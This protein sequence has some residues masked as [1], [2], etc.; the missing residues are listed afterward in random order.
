MP[1]IYGEGGERAFLRLQEHIMSRTRDYSILAWGFQNKMMSVSTVYKDWTPGGVFAASP[2]DFQH[3]DSIVR[4]YRHNEPL[5][6]LEISAGNVRAS[7]SLI[8]S[9]LCPVALLNCAPGGD[10]KRIIGIV[11]K[12]T[13]SRDANEYVRRPGCN[14]VKE[15]NGPTHIEGEQKTINIRTDSRLETL[16]FGQVLCVY[17]TED[18][19]DLGMEVADVWPRSAWDSKQPALVPKTLLTEARVEHPM[20]VRFRH[21]EEG[22]RDFFLAIYFRQ[23]GYTTTIRSY[24]IATCSRHTPLEEISGELP[25]LTERVFGSTKASNRALNLA[26]TVEAI[27]GTLMWVIRPHRMNRTPDVTIDATVELQ[28]MAEAPLEE[29]QRRPLASRLLSKLRRDEGVAAGN[30]S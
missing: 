27:P 9:A 26:L 17:N 4:L 5:E 18:F 6:T 14:P 1:L 29:S 10:P 12:S 21:E 24:C 8:G 25:R 30:A 15:A 7:L 16:A 13:R 2:S 22:S 28:R 11:L 20:L 3:S 19:A 23:V